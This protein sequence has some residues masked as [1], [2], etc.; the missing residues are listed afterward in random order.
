VEQPRTLECEAAQD[1]DGWQVNCDFTVN[2]T[3]HGITI[4]KIMFLKLAEDIRVEIDMRLR[5]APTDQE[6]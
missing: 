1:G 5:P 6:P 3:D 2:L 4:P